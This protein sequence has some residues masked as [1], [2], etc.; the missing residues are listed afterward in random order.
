MNKLVKYKF[1]LYQNVEYYGSLVNVAIVNKQ[2]ENL[3][4]LLNM[5][6]EEKNKECTKIITALDDQDNNC[7]LLAVQ[8][9]LGDAV[10]AILE[11]LC[12]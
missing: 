9:N 10:S 1:D 11:Y 6:R 2:T 5:L 7:L 3:M 12:E 8:L 4:F